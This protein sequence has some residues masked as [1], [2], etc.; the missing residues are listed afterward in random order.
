M[1]RPAYLAIIAAVITTVLSGGCGGGSST[2]SGAGRAVINITWPDRS[3]LIPLASNSIKVVFT[4][5]AQVVDSQLIPRPVSGN[6]TQTTFTNLKT[7]SLILTATAFPNADGSGVAQAS[8]TTP[9]TITSGQ[10]TA[11]TLT[12]DSTIDHLDLNSLYPSVAVSNTVQLIGTAKNA[13]GSVVLTSPSKLQWSTSD[14]AVATVDSGGIV[15]GVKV[16][17]ASISVVEAESG[18]SVSAVVTVSSG[19]GIQF[20]PEVDYAVAPPGD[21]ANADIDGDGFLDIVFCDGYDQISVLYGKGDGTFEPVV[22][23]P[24]ANGTAQIITADVNGDGRPDVVFCHTNGNELGVLINA[25][26]RTFAPVVFYGVGQRP[27]GV[28]AGDFNGDGKLDLAAANDSTHDMCVLL[29][30]GSGTFGAPTFYAGGSFPAKVITADFNGD[31]KLDLAMCNDVSADVYIYFG[32][33]AGGFTQNGTYKVGNQAGQIIKADFNK[34]GKLD[35]ATANTFDHT[36][37]ILF[38]DGAGIFSVTGPYPA[39]TYPHIMWPADLDGDGWPDI[40]APN[41]GTN[42]FTVLKNTGAGIFGAPQK[43]TTNGNNVRTMTIGDF[44]R[45]GKPDIAVGAESSSLICVFINNS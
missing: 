18:K 45:D 6:Q 36:I 8:G 20:L 17:S 14:A 21:L 23:Y 28:C 42:Y 39:N 34:D 26:V 19:Q 13:S 7:G 9:V 33:G 27:F 32:N 11:V 31:G 30:Q 24:G 2:G 38:G 41:N 10:T 37:S 16:G 40:A 35:L 4:Q 15:T 1:K 5:G 43:I 22:S 12:M 29:N 44:N 3:R 25:G